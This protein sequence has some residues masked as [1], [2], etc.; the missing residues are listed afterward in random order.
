MEEFTYENPSAQSKDGESSYQQVSPLFSKTVE[1]VFSEL[2][3][4]MNERKRAAKQ[5]AKMTQAFNEKLME[6]KSLA[7]RSDKKYLEQQL[8]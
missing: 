1:D 6:L 3:N 5:Y 2:V 8:K 7:N 4:C